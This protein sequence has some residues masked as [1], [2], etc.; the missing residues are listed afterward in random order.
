LGAWTRFARMTHTGMWSCAAPRVCRR[1]VLHV[2]H[3]STQTTSISQPARHQEAHL[4]SCRPRTP[5]AAGARPKAPSCCCCCCRHWL[6][7]GRGRLGPS[8]AGCWAAHLGEQQQQTA[9][10]GIK[11]TGE[12][13]PVCDHIDKGNHTATCKHRKQK[14]LTHASTHEEHTAVP[15]ARA[16]VAAQQAVP[17]QQHACIEPQ[18]IEPPSLMPHDEHCMAYLW[19][20]SRWQ[21]CRQWQA[22][23]ESIHE[24]HA[25]HELVTVQLACR[26]THGGERGQ[27]AACVDTAVAITKNAQGL[28]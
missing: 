15:V 27:A 17:Y 24:E 22:P 12:C 8:Q 13:V 9:A 25:A 5:H 21:H 26:G 23:P 28:T 18:A 14:E 16:Q 19:P 4:G 7:V 3:V 1:T 11:A 20:G 2:L 10:A 6:L